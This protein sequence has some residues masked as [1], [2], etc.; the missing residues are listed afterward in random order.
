MHI[1]GEADD[2][3]LLGQDPVPTI[4]TWGEF[5][6][7]VGIPT[8]ILFLILWFVRAWLH[9]FMEDAS[10]REQRMAA[11][12]DKLEEFAQGTL[13]E[14]IGECRTALVEST[15]VIQ[16]LHKAVIT[17]NDEVRELIIKMLERPCLIKHPE[18]K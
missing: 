7:T 10:L 17:S 6:T 5:A 18:Q 15:D 9:K 1:R 2:L 3:G 12:I 4:H 11:R 16:E 14:L 13:I 8:A